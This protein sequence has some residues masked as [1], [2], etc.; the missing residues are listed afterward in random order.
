MHRNKVLNLLN[1]YP[2]QDEIKR[3]FI[4]FVEEN[5]KCFDRENNYGHFTGSGWLVNKNG[6]KVLLTHHRKLNM[7]LQ[8]GGHC[9][10]ESDVAKVALTEA[11]EETGI[12]SWKFVDEAIFDIDCHLIPA[13]KTEPEH[14]HFDIRFVFVCGENEDYIVSEESH[15]LAWVPIDKLAD[16]TTEESIVRMAQK[17]QD[18]SRSLK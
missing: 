13:R 17:W 1:Q 4:S 5:D 14:F 9:D 7:W 12:E 16:Y 11:I 2:E 6:D 18:Y 15:D 10:G 3:K 8:P